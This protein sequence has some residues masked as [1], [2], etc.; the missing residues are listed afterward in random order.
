M[1]SYD[2]FAEYYEASYASID[3]D[4]DFYTEMV[5]RVGARANVLELACGSGRV[6]LP[7]LEEGYRVTGLDASAKM[8]EI[9]RRKVVA[10]GYDK[11]VRLVQDDMRTFDFGGE[12]FDFIFVPLNSFQHLLTQPDQ[13]ACLETTRRHLAPAGLFILSVVN[14]EDKES[15]PADGRVELSRQFKNPTNGNQVQ[16][17]LS[18]V[19]EPQLQVRHYTY[20]Y[21]EIL[22]DGTVKRTVAEMSLRYSY[23]YELELLLDKA[24]F[25][26][27]ELYGSYD[28]EDYGA[29]S[30]RL[31]YVCRRK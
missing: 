18:T 31:I 21:D 11:Q 13:L 14:A 16:V 7:L 19:A 3:M 22:P 24:G 12:Q 10:E 9:A 1:D 28:F 20:F 4:L 15:Y 6:T 2:S 23:R 5:K 26:V 25:S 30:S 27:E 17:F 29:G 8:L